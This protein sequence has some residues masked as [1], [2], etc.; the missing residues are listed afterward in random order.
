MRIILVLLLAAFVTQAQQTV[1]VTV[2]QQVVTVP[3]S[4]N[5]L[6][7]GCTWTATG[8]MA[9]VVNVVNC[10]VPPS[11]TGVTVT[12]PA[13]VTGGATATYTATVQGTGSPSQSV[14]WS[15]SSGTISSAGVFTA[16]AATG[17]AMIKATSVAD[18][19]KSGSLPVAITPQGQIVTGCTVQTVLPPGENVI[20]IRQ[21][22]GGTLV[23]TQPAGVQGAVM[24]GPQLTNGF[25]WWQVTFKT[26]P[27]GWVGEDA[28]KVVGSPS[29]VLINWTAPASPS[30]VGYNVYRSTATGGP[31]GKLTAAPVVLNSYADTNLTHGTRYYYVVTALGSAMVYKTP[32]SANSNEASVTP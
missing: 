15:A 18:A 19:M 1:P 26:G 30:I 31:Y 6:P 14:T 5:G 12:G 24:A 20:N 21:T 22:P 28:L 3:V 16:P 29:A 2:P 27:S 7:V 23:G 17:S 8:G 13:S 4:I 9:I 10:G 25:N 32:E 11:V